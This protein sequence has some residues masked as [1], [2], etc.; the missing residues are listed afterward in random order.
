LDK[1]ALEQLLQSQYSGLLSLLRRKIQDPQVAAD[2]LNDAIVTS[3]VHLRNGRVADPNALAG[4]VFQVA[5]NLYR[6]HRRKHSEQTGKRASVDAIDAVAAPAGTPANADDLAISRQVRVI[7]SEMPA[8]R[9]RVVLT[10]FY[11]QE[12]DKDVICRDLGLSPLHFDKVI[13][14]ARKRMKELLESHGF[15]KTDFLG[16][17]LLACA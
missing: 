7:M 9:D 4:Y 13:F 5:M 2:L 15:K 14:R 12:D 1:D 8:E 11:L 10:R 17:A 3:L 6:N 16:L